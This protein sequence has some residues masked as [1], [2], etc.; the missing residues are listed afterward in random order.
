MML[1]FLFKQS[2]GL[3]STT[4]IR[5]VRHNGG[6][7][8]SR[9]VALVPPLTT[10]YPSSRTTATMIQSSSFFTS[11]ETDLVLLP[12][13]TTTTTTTTPALVAVVALSLLIAAQSFIN[14]MLEGDQGLAAFLKDGSGYNKSAFRSI[15]QQQQQQTSLSS[16]SSKDPLPWLK[17]PQLDF[18]DVA[19]QE[20]SPPRRKQIEIIEQVQ[21]SDNM[22]GVYQELEQ[23]RLKMNREL[24]EENIDEAK[25]MQSQ[26]EKLMNDYGIEYKTTTAGDEESTFQ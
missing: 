17:L 24:Q 4:R 8:T 23:L 2:S 11:M 16:S 21:V 9:L 26:L 22:E 19:G 3:L 7:T 5:T 15:K 10:K 20:K 1:F 13:M 6:V 14:Q 25:R 18:V 12:D